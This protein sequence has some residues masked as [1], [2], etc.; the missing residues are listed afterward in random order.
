M[1]DVGDAFRANREFV[2]ELKRQ[3]AVENA[4]YLEEHGTEWEWV[5]KGCDHILIDGHLDYYLGKTYYFDR[6]TKKSGYAMLRKLLKA[7]KS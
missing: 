5:D 4:S 6:D 1:G 3:R 2:K 7:R